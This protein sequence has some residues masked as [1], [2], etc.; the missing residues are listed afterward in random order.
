M[1]R[2]DPEYFQ[3]CGPEGCNAEKAL[4]FCTSHVQS[5][6]KRYHDWVEYYSAF[7]HGMN[8]DLL[9]VNDGKVDFLCGP[10]KFVGLD[11]HLGRPHMSVS[12]GVKRSF[13]YGVDYAIKNNYKWLA[14]VE[15][16]CY[17]LPAARFEFMYRLRTPGYGMPFCRTY[18]FPECNLQI[19][20]DQRVRKTM[21]LWN[22]EES[23]WF[24][25]EL[26]EARLGKLGAGEVFI[27]ER[28]EGIPE[29][30]KPG[31]NYIA[32]ITLTDLIKYFP[33]LVNWRD[34]A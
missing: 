5:D 20:N 6:P 19:I 3:R 15:S 9:M 25:S 33:T 17:V 22:S 11:P 13:G 28:F 1:S 31:F 26:F 32:Q 12:A 16:D 29:R 4:V 27:G 8:V 30:I 2:L 10:A 34:P 23:D 21:V 18:N 24:A 14:F 7:F